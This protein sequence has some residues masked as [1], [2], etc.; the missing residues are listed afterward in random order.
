M[1]VGTRADPERRSLSLQHKIDPYD[2]S[3]LAVPGNGCRVDVMRSFP[4]P[5]IVLQVSL[6]IENS[7]NGA[8]TVSTRM[9]LASGEL[10]MFMEYI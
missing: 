1:S 5:R 7:L 6:N 8:P 3:A 4:P 9:A 2:V 10:F